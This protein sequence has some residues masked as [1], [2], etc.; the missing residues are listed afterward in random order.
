MSN[1]YEEKRMAFINLADRLEAAKTKNKDVDINKLLVLMT[2]QYMIGET[3]IL[4]RLERIRRIRG[5]FEINGEL[6]IWNNSDGVKKK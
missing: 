1:F 5:D 6:L 4:K 3:C 2:D